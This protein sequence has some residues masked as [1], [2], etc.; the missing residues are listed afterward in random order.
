[1]RR[2]EE[3][4]AAPRELEEQI[5][6][7]APRDRIDAGGRFVEKKNGRLMHQRASHRE[8][9][10]PAAGEKRGAAVEVGLEMSERD[11][12]VAALSSGRRSRRL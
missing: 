9:L 8:A 2:D 5:P 7:L 10:T 6:Q 11:Q 1:M 12:F 3:R 4:H